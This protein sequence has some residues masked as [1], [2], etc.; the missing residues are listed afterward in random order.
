MRG[1]C[2]HRASA[3][4]RCGRGR[5]DRPRYPR[6]GAERDTRR[7]TDCGAYR[8]RWDYNRG[9]AHR[10]APHV[11]GKGV[12]IDVTAAE[13][14]LRDDVVDRLRA[15]DIRYIGG[16]NAWSGRPMLVYQG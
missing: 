9:G 6:T 14:A 7:Y 15:H 5:D 12:S 2:P 3:L 16:G 8:E 4:V 11:E 10:M 13:D 1:E